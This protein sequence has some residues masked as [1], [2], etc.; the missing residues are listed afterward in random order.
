MR[1]ALLC[2]A[3][4]A[5]CRP[6]G[7]YLLDTPY[8]MRLLVDARRDAPRAATL[9]LNS[10]LTGQ[11]HPVEGRLYLK[12]PERMRLVDMDDTVAVVVAKEGAGASGEERALRPHK[13]GYTLLASLLSPRGRDLDD[14]SARL[15]K[16]LAASAIDPNVVALGRQDEQVVYIIGAQPWEGERPQVWLDK[17]SFMPVRVRLPGLAPDG[18][19]SVQELRLLEYGGAAVPGLPRVWEAYQDG[20]L[21]R[22]SEVVGGQVNAELPEALFDLSAPPARRR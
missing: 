1:R 15:V 20:T 17:A 8:L 18:K 21:V 5:V 19:S 10:E 6:A 3:L 16:A 2:L 9:T 12:R 13:D 4:L 22:R 11:D 7:A 14:A